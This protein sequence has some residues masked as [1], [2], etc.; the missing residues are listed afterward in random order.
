[1][2]DYT[3]YATAFFVMLAL[4]GLVDM[5]LNLDIPSYRL[6][7]GSGFVTLVTGFIQDW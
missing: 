3:K 4:A 7:I 6:W 5:V 1:M 2:K